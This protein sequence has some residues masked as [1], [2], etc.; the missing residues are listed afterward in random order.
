MSLREKKKLETKNNIFE[1]S[2]R[3]F[4]EKGFENTTIDEITREVGIAKGTFFNYFPTK[5]S[6][7]LYFREQ[8]HELIHELL[9]AEKSKNVPT[10]E[11]IK[12]FLVLLAESYEKDKELTKLFILE[13]KR[14]AV[15]SGF[16]PDNG[17]SMHYRFSRIL[18]DFLEEGAENGEIKSTVDL[19]TAAEMLNVV[20]FHTLIVWLRSEND[21][22][23]SR[24]ISAKIDLLFEG[25]RN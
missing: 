4:K 10:K 7:L 14:Y 3:L 1:V 9:E 18:H 25:I 20:Y 17:N 6:L 16:S 11:K 23:F 15:H 21:F 22:P 13:Y 24:N 5:G 12:G 19:E 8:K 2:G